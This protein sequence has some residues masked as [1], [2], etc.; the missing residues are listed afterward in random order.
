[1]NVSAAVKSSFLAGLILL[2]PLVVTLYVLRLL[3]NWSLQFVNP[4]VRE[5]RLTQ[6]TANIEV[7]AQVLAVVLILGSITVLGYLAQQR[8]GREMFGN[9]GQ[10]VNVIPLV[11]TIY[12]GVRQV[13]NSLVDRDTAYESVVLVEYPRK[14]VYSIGLVT[15]ESPPVAED[16]A[17]CQLYNVFLPH[18]PNPTAG[19]LVLLPDEQIHEVDMS[20]RQGMRLIVTSGIGTDQ[21]PST[22]PRLDESAE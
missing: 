19:R 10:V 8:V 9:L 14:D 3:V 4:V 13:A 18:S 11:S 15:G 6:Y 5:T 16:V 22:L 17:G 20:V 21:S 12:V 2:T 7:V 1:M